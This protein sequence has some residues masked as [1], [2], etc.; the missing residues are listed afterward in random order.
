V[1]WGNGSTGTSGVVSAANSL[2]GSTK[3]DQVGYC[4]FSN[5]V[6]ALSN[7]NYVV[8]SWS[9]DN[10]AA[11]DAGA[12]TLGHG[13]ACGA[14][15][16]AGPISAANSVLGGSSGAIHTMNFSYDAVNHQLV[17]GRPEDNM[18][19]LVAASECTFHFFPR[20]VK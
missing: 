2:V 16:T 13:M 4:L 19:S 3:G 6:T 10:G 9:W 12:L 17:V 5:C 1:T 18:V 11:V 8:E 14:G 15:P 20:I 7:S